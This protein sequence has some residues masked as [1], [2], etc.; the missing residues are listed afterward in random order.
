MNGQRIVHIVDNDPEIQDSLSFMLRAEGIGATQHS[1]ALE[2]LTALDALKPGCLIIDIRMPGM[3][4]LDLQEELHRRGCQWPVIIVTGH[5]DVETAVHAMKAGA[6]DF[7]QKPFAKADL[8]AALDAA[9]ARTAEHAPPTAECLKAAE[10]IA[11]L[12]RRERQIVDG[13]VKGQVNKTIAHALGISP[14]TVE[15]HRASAMRK[16]AVHSLSELLH[17]AFLAEMVGGQDGA[18]DSARA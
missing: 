5:G 14:R 13:L 17:I 2:L 7:L 12:S 16:L 9:F 4:G 6:V 1:S 8:M 10:S 11:S 3:S 18:E 15:I